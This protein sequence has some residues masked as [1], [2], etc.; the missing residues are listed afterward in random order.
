MEDRAYYVYLLASQR[1]GTL[2]LG[3]TSKLAQR[4][5]EH[6]QGFVAGFTRS[7]RTHKLVWYEIHDSAYAAICREKQLK[8]WERAWKIRIV[9]EMN[10]YWNDLSSTL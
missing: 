10:P 2:Y 5:W 8:R 1:N 6:R 3:V 9:E 4:I 7:Y